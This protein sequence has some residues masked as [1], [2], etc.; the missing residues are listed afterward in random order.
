MTRQRGSAASQEPLNRR[1]VLTDP[2]I[3][4]IGMKPTPMRIIEAALAELRQLIRARYPDAAFEI[5]RGEDPEGVYLRVIVGIDDPDEV[6]DVILRRLYDFEVEQALPI[7]VIPV[8]TPEAAPGSLKNGTA[9]CCSRTSA[10]Q[11]S[12]QAR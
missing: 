12:V 10:G 6:M 3:K 9:R 11:D 4:F 5:F 8:R 7:Y 1:L 2:V